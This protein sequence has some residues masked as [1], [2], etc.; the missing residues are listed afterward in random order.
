MGYVFP[1]DR[2]QSK[3]AF[4]RLDIAEVKVYIYK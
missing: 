4:T 3:A 2:I 1:C